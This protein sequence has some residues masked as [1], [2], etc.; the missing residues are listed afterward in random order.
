VVI[1][2]TYKRHLAAIHSD[3]VTRSNVIGLR[4]LLNATARKESR[5]SVSCTSPDV[6]PEQ[7]YWL[8][9]AVERDQPRVTGELHDSGLALLRS[10][11]YA[12]R[13][14]PVADIIA[15]IDHFCLSGFEWL[16][17]YHC[18]PVYLA[19]AS[20]GRSFTFRNVPWQSGGNGPEILP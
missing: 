19:K 14:A 9:E 1:S 2:N 20:D 3:N 4:K 13:L 15:A 5:L 6:T 12:K 7:A 17:S 18:V 16:D 10:K 11:R 8:Q